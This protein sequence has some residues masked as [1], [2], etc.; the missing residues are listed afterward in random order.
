MS[1][2]KRIG[3][4]LIERGVISP[5][6]LKIA[7]QE[8]SQTG[9]K[10]GKVL[11]DLGFLT[12]SLLTDVLGE[13]RGDESIDLTEVVPDAEAIALIDKKLAQQHKVLPCDFD[14]ETRILQ[15]AMAD[16]YDILALDR[17]K[18]S[19]APDITIAP[20]LAGAKDIEASIDPFY[21]YELSIDGI[22]REIETGEYEDS[23]QGVGTAEYSHPLVRLVDAFLTDAVKRG[24]SDIHFEPEEG[25]LRIRYRIDGVLHQIRSLHDKYWPAIVVR[26][27]VMSSM[28]LA[29]TRAPQDGRI[30]LKVAGHPID[31]RVAT[32]PTIHGENFVLRILDRDKSI[33]P[34]EKL[35]MAE[36]N[37]NLLKLMMARPEGIILV[38]GP[39]GS[40]KTTTLYS[41]LNH[42][43][44]ESVNIMTLEDPVE[45]PLGLIRQT[46][47]GQSSKM[48]F[49]DGIRSL[50]RQDPDIILVGEMRDKETAEMG[51]QAAMT[52]HQ[53]FS[54]LHTNS[55]IGA[56][57]RLQDIGVLPDIMSGNLIGI[58]G[59]RLIR[60]LCPNCKQER[61]IE[62]VE[63]RLL[64]INDDSITSLYSHQG[65]IHCHGTGYKGRIALLE[66]LRIDADLDELISRKASQREFLQLAE[67]KGFKP[68]AHDGINQVIA[69]RTTLE[70]LTRVVDLTSR[71]TN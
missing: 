59:Q 9:E 40:G 62:D 16:T 69:G 3:D 21:G 11:I 67:Q 42:L 60:K 29:E 36:E 31:F 50:M 6:Q 17:V 49:A 33:V 71:L 19:I 39:T 51:F 10:I 45:Y 61:P 48:G 64:D 38:T 44:N 41:M 12:E 13:T 5:D 65:C 70:E 20:V 68:L 27:K 22:L 26:L 2:K 58:I 63:K 32:Q 37:R 4:Q 35:E 57:P 34:L 52:G 53:V 24:A 55:A 46:S 15:L 30:H 14:P 28:D 18:A 1:P 54:T 56:F 7:L 23:H 43:N 25:F 47:I 66:V 8:Q